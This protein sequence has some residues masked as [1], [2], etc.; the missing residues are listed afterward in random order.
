VSLSCPNRRASTLTYVAVVASLVLLS[1]VFA[2]AESATYVGFTIT[3]GKLGSWSF[4]NARVYLTFQGDTNNVQ[5]MQVPDP[6]DPNCA[7]PA[8]SNCFMADIYLNATGKAGI[9]IISGTKIVH[10]NF[11]PNQ[12]F[13]ALDMGNAGDVHIGARGV[14]FSS[15]S[16]TIPGG[17]DPLYPLGVADGTLDFGDYDGFG[18][19]S[20]E[21]YTLP[22]DLQHSV[23]L[24]GRGFVCSNFNPDIGGPCAASPALHTDSGNLYLYQPYLTLDNPGFMGSWFDSTNAG[25]FITQM[26]GEIG[27]L[28][29]TALARPAIVSFYPFNHPIA[30]NG[31][32]ITD[33]SLNGKT[34]SNAQVYLTFQGD[35][36]TAHA[37]P[38]NPHGFI[39]SI[40]TA[41]VRIISGNTSISADLNPGQVY[42]YYDPV[43]ASV[44]F[45]SAAGGRGYPFRLA[46]NQDIGGLVE[47]SSIGA[48][49][50]LTLTPAD[51]AFYSPATANLATNLRNYTVLSGAATSCTSLDVATSTCNNLTPI[52]LST[53]KG[54]LYL[55][56]PYTAVDDNGVGPFSVNWGMFWS[57]PVRVL[58]NND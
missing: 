48:V 42:V 46:A 55:Y 10:A 30:Y 2:G 47:D 26:E 33:V 35:A 6:G 1:A 37:D 20:D 24:S 4:H 11:A 53:N 22:F 27:N 23:G 40:G 45:G 39:N 41:H 34:Y 38:A 52:P 29:P 12:V 18:F 13:V 51:A 54:A 32:T 17:V 19:P 9:T 36:S 50:D 57:E 43:T 3:D 5:L 56:E 15:F 25:F 58:L 7:P 14:A 21:L 44:G 16:A 28:I 49:S 31:Y 8:N